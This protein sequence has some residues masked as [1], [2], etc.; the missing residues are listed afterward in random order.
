[1]ASAEKLLALRA[2]CNIHECRHDLP[3]RLWTFRTQV[4]QQLRNQRIVRGRVRSS[5]WSENTDA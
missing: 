2:H 5:S 1:M 3:H 4:F